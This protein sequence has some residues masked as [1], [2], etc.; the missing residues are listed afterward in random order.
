MIFQFDYPKEKLSHCVFNPPGSIS[1]PIQA[2][3][4]STEKRRISIL[5][6][7]YLPESVKGND[8]RKHGKLA[9]VSKFWKACFVRAD[10]GIS[11]YDFRLGPATI[12]LLIYDKTFILQLSVLSTRLHHGLCCVLNFTL[13]QTLLNGDRWMI[14][15]IT[16]TIIT[17]YSFSP[18]GGYL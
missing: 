11:E 9:A 10:K 6:L 17:I 12:R 15:V 2:I 18:F 7:Y 16:N 8:D 14:I 5:G 1:S 4:K 3:C 13:I